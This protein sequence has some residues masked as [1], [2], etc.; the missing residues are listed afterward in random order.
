MS[1]SATGGTVATSDAV[2]FQLGSSRVNTVQ[3][4]IGA[5]KLFIGTA[6]EEFTM[7]GSGLEAISAINPPLVRSGTTEGSDNLPAIRIGNRVIF[8]QRSGREVREL[9]FNDTEQNLV[10]E[11][12]SLIADHFLRAPEFVVTMAYQNKPNRM[13]W[14]VRSDGMLLGLC[15]YIAEKVRAWALMGSTAA[16]GLYKWVTVIPSVDLL[17][18]QA[19]FIVQRTIGG[20]TKHFVELQNQAISVHSGLTYSGSPVSAVAGIDHLNGQTVKVVGDGAVYDDQVVTRGS[21]SLAYGASSGPAAS[22]IAIGLAITPNPSLSTLQPS[23]KD[24]AGSTR[25]KLKHWAS[26]AF[27]LENTLGLTI[28]G[29][30]QVQYRKPSDPMDSVEPSFTGTKQVANLGWSR[31]GLITAEQTLPLPATILGYSGECEIG[32]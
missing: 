16:S 20:V 19:W 30:T 23:L 8:A 25:H 29:K 10:T 9:T 13:L 15:N 31:D 11:E 1:P 6:G 18:D 14:L 7:E 2:T 22:T 12:L 24:Q 3:W 4:L 26:L 27:E 17:D 5:Q 32:D 28:N 21:V